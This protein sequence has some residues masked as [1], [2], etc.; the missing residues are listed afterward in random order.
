MGIGPMNNDDGGSKGLVAGLGNH[1]VDERVENG[2]RDEGGGQVLG[3]S[4]E[5]ELRI[6]EVAEEVKDGP[7]GLTQ[8]STSLL[9]PQQQVQGP[10]IRWERFL[11][12]RTLKVLLVE[13][14]DSTRHVVSALLHNCSYEVTAVANGLQAWKVLE[15]LTNHIDLVL[16]EVVMPVLS[17]IGLLCKI[18]SHKT[19]KNIPV[20][21]M[22]SHDPMGIVFKCLSKGAVDFLVKPIR[23]NELKNLW[24]HVW[25]RC[26]SSSSSGSESGIRTQKSTKSK[27]NDESENNSGSSDERNYGSIGLSIR[28]GSDDGSADAPDSTCAQ[29]IHAKLEPVS[30]RWAHINETSEHK[31]QDEKCDT[32]AMG[33]D[34]EIGVSGNP[35]LHLE[36][37]HEKYST[38]ARGKRMMKLP[39]F[40]GKQFDN[41]NLGHASN[42]TGDK[43]QDQAAILTCTVGN[44]TDPQIERV[45][46]D[47]PDAL[48]GVSQIK[49]KASLNRREL[50]SLDLSLKRLRGAGDAV[51]YDDHNVLRHSDLSAFS[52]YNTS[53]S[54]NQAATGKIR[55]CSPLG[56][57][58]TAIKMDAANN[59]PLNSSGTPPN[60]Q[61]NES[62]NNND[63][64]STMKGI[65]PK[66]EPFS[67]K[68]ESVSAPKYFQSTACPN[69]SNVHGCLIQQGLPG[70]ADDIA[71]NNVG[72]QGEF[73]EEVHIQHHHHHHHHYHHHVHNILQ[74]QQRTA[75]PD[76]DELSLKNMDAAA[77]QCGSSYVLGGPI[78]GVAGNY[79]VNGSASG[80]NHGSN[81]QNGSSTALN[82][83][84]TNVESDNGGAGSNG[85]AGTGISGRISG[86]GVDE[87]RFAQREAALT[88][89]RQ[90]RKER[91]FEKKVR[92]QSRKKLA[93][94]RPRVRGQFVKQA[95][96]NSNTGK[97]LQNDGLTSGDDACNR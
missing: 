8:V 39:E 17:G 7:E 32:V 38:Q 74:Q 81:G 54:A 87:D 6:E 59:L 68:A 79:S 43:P 57:S 40:Y 48:S 93:E 55:S 12:I 85:A 2:N 52:K 44:C 77:P 15:D 3:L 30:S 58:S 41:G 73:H 36:N 14:D 25:R 96:S 35:D 56:N 80:S 45:G 72:P 95:V 46:Y 83:G 86:N 88:K 97:D 69:L 94:Q 27:S 76:H 49:D 60:Q 37:Q 75:H 78:E 34:M 71:I 62:S 28:D 22:S 82:A 29:F 51:M 63:M 5:D 92:Y 42:N 70:K 26:H 20:I 21:M 23:K 66:S 50:P 53:S 24:Q 33:R 91:C 61:S 18:M 9:K 47:A 13:S 1:V 10:V 90:K 16:T 4:K 11:P 19:F 65:I 67:K 64:A 84:L 89:F 31:E